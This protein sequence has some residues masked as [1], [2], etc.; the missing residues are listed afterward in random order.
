MALACKATALPIMDCPPADPAAGDR[1]KDAMLCCLTVRRVLGAALSRS[2]IRRAAGRPPV[3]AV[4]TTPAAV[5]GLR[6]A[7]ARP[8]ERAANGVCQGAERDTLAKACAACPSCCCCWACWPAGPAAPCC[9][10]CCCCASCTLC[11]LCG[12]G[13]FSTSCRPNLAAAWASACAARPRSAASMAALPPPASEL[14]AQGVTLLG[15]IAVVGAC[16][17]SAA[18]GVPSP[19]SGPTLS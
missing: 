12:G 13:R 18:R 2:A 16:D 9:C 1:R 14:A 11:M 7:A 3:P 6:P 5:A 19:G 8:P 10:C 17:R 15:V 4:A